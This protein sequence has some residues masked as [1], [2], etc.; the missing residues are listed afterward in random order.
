MKSN[1]SLYVDSEASTDPIFFT[2]SVFTKVM[3]KYETG[4]FG[5]SVKSA[6]AAIQKMMDYIDHN[7]AM[8]TEDS[9]GME[10]YKRV[11][12][13]HE[14][15]QSI[16]RKSKKWRDANR[17]ER[18]LLET[19]RVIDNYKNPTKQAT[20]LKGFKNY[21]KSEERLKKLDKLIQYS[22]KDAELPSISTFVEMGVHVME[23]TCVVGGNISFKVKENHDIKITF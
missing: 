1:H 5:G 7:F 16:I 11:K 17:Q 9:K 15:V 19:N 8:K 4:A 14:I 13:I 23:E 21:L 2:A 10:V 20:I 18:N 3:K 22:K 6:L 12:E